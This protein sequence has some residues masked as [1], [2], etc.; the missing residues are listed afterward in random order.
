MMGVDM[1]RVKRTYN[2][3]DA[4]VRHVREMSAEYGVAESQDAVVELAVERLYRD[5]LDRV[6]GERWAA[7]AAD[8]AF[9]AEMREVAAD[10]DGDESWPT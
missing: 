2:L 7:A 9:V 4:T 10:L 5:A 3:D 6:E 8:P 1:T